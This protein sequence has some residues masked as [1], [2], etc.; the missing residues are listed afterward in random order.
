MYGLS[1]YLSN[2]SLINAIRVVNSIT[3]T[4]DE[5]RIEGQKFIRKKVSKDDFAAANEIQLYQKLEKGTGLYPKSLP[6]HCYSYTRGPD[7]Y[8]LSTY[9]D[10]IPLKATTAT[11]ELCVKILNDVLLAL[12][13]LHQNFMAH[14]NVKPTNILVTPKSAIL[15]DFSNGCNNT[16]CEGLEKIGVAAYDELSAQSRIRGVSMIEWQTAD[17]WVLV[18]TL[19]QWINSQGVTGQRARTLLDSMHAKLKHGYQSNT[20]VT[21][22]D[23][24]KMIEKFWGTGHGPDPDNSL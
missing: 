15:V 8:L 4:T 21:A 6:H 9:V 24:L 2:P 13:F 12:E 7:T 14:R 16:I 19:V 10:G 18:T 23:L 20:A 1:E 17:L 22:T 5:V 3:P 11:E